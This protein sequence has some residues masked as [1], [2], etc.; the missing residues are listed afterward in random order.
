MFVRGGVCV[1]QWPPPLAPAVAPSGQR[2]ERNRSR[3]SSSQVAAAATEVETPFW[4]PEREAPSERASEQPSEELDWAS[5]RGGSGA[6]R[7]AAAP[8]PSPSVVSGS[9]KP[10]DALEQL[11]VYKQAEAAKQQQQLMFMSGPSISPPAASSL[12]KPPAARTPP[13]PSHSQPTQ[14]CAVFVKNISFHT[15]AEHL[16]ESFS[17]FGARASEQARPPQPA[18]FDRSCVPAPPCFYLGGVVYSAACTLHP[19]TAP[20]YRNR[21]ADQL[22]LC[23]LSRASAQ[24]RSSRCNPSWAV[25]CAAGA[26]SRHPF[27]RAVW[28]ICTVCL[29]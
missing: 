8:S 3:R 11:R 23:E 21:T 26:C 9:A 20:M 4:Q 5:M 13:P 29:V 1:W 16:E 10:T 28:S 27:A 12:P 14:S 22:Y 2:G 19:N 6:S 15:S 24:V 7:A 25:S 17:G 18:H